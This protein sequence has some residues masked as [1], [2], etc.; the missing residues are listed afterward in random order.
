MEFRNI[1]CAQCARILYRTDGASLRAP[2]DDEFD[3]PL[4]PVEMVIAQ[5]LR[6]ICCSSECAS[7]WIYSK[8]TEELL[9]GYPLF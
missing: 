5:R 4:R 1:A 2:T 3:V 6:I 8:P 7:R 9:G